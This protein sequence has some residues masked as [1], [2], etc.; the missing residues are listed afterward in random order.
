MRGSREAGEH[1]ELAFGR[2]DCREK[3]IMSMLLVTIVVVSA[4]ATSQVSTGAKPPIPAKIE[5]FLRNCETNRRGA[6]L[7]LEHQLRGLRN[8]ARPT[9]DM[10][11]RIAL[12]EDDVKVLRANQQP[13]VSTLSF[14]PEIGAI[15]RVPR[16]SWH[17][18]QI[19]SDREII[20]RCFFNVRTTTVRRYVA[21]GEIRVQ[22]VS[23]VVRGIETKELR[24]GSDPPVPQVFEITGRES[25]PLAGGGSSRI[26]V[27]KPF[28]MA[29]AL[30]Y[31]PLP[32]PK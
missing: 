32:G 3:L 8:E 22:P 12:L 6:I 1:G 18:D 2:R 28:D 19:I 25:Y 14:P 17:I 27:L 13:V 5:K 30:A 4:S 23:F 11:R 29:A 10:V 24:E 21:R 16:L 7:Q 26:W 15:G 9:P 31:F 20:V